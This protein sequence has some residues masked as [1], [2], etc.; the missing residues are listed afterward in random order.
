MAL[1]K[2]LSLKLTQIGFATRIIDSTILKCIIHTSKERKEF[3]I[4]QELALKKCYESA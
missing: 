3:W 1:L 4:L 2:L